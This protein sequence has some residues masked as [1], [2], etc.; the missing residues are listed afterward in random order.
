MSTTQPDAAAADR[1]SN[2]SSS[3]SPNKRKVLALLE[4]AKDA[5]SALREELLMLSIHPLESKLVGQQ[6]IDPNAMSTTA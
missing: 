1:F 6:F 5:A 4:D 3:S 2:G